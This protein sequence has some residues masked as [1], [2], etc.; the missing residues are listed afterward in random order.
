MRAAIAQCTSFGYVGP[1][2]WN[3]LPHS[4][5]LELLS[6]SHLQAQRWLKTVLFASPSPDAVREHCCLEWRYIVIWLYAYIKSGHNIK[7]DLQLH[8]TWQSTNWHC[9]NCT[10]Y[11]TN[12]DVQVHNCDPLH[13]KICP[14]LHYLWVENRIFNKFKEIV[15]C[16]YCQMSSQVLSFTRFFYTDF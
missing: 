16:W 3:S 7:Q 14:A 2:D 15:L 11:S 9:S 12:F 10:F 4:L 8:K 6:L 5:H 1:S 13:V